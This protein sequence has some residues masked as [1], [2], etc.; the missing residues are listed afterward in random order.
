MNSS[1]F[2]QSNS[3]ASWEYLGSIFKA[4]SS[5]WKW[6]LVKLDCFI[7]FKNKEPCQKLCKIDFQNLQVP[8]PIGLTKS[9]LFAVKRLR[10]VYN[11]SNPFIANRGG[12]ERGLADSKL[13]E[14]AYIFNWCLSSGMYIVELGCRCGILWFFNLPSA[15]KLIFSFKFNQFDPFSQMAQ[16][17]CQKSAI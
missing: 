16:K 15:K 10:G 1:L 2:P 14:N 12:G 3:R 13:P 5:C 17:V 4:I 9:T 8:K 11:S 7:T 6:L